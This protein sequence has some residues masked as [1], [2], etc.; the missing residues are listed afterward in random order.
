MI[1]ENGTTKLEEKEPLSLF[2]KH[3]LRERR[4]KSLYRFSF[5]ILIT[6][7][8][9]FLLF[10]VIAGIA[11]VKGDSMMPSLTDGS[12]ALFYRLDSTYERNDI[13]IFKPADE[14][15]YLI[16]RVVA[17]EGDTVDIDNKTGELLINGIVQKED[18]IIG[19]TYKREDG[20]EFP[21]TVPRD[22]V[23]VMGDNREVALDSR[24]LGTI[25]TQNLIGKVVFEI[26][27]LRD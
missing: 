16:K 23:F 26:K 5:E 18:T 3:I 19:E 11:I 10:G 17:I 14:D 20:V 9:V 8:V 27:I 7:A 4:K 13:V 21:L 2:E 6:A 12:F 1:V 25:D 24:Y 15:E 22:F